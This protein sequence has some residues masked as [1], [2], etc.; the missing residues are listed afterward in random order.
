MHIFG[1]LTMILNSKLFRT[2]VILLITVV[3]NKFVS[4]RIITLLR[5][6][7]DKTNG[8][9]DENRLNTLFSVLRKVCSV[10]IYFIGIVY[11]MQIL[12]N[13]NPASVI[14]ATGVVGVAVGFASQ[15][16]VKDTINGFLILFENQY[17]I[18]EKV[19]IDG[20]CGTV[21]EINL[22]ATR[23]KNDDGDIFIIPN[24]AIIKVI[25]HSR[26]N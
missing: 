26:K 18:G 16:L 5:K 14:A 12:F 13:V 10:V 25:N 9:A 6:G 19:T 4:H 8:S 17:S 23:I 7:A 1:I 20:F 2:A 3:L 22:R 21:S 11:V 15:S 24:S